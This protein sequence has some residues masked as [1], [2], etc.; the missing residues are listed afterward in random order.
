M[1]SKKGTVYK[2]VLK[3]RK[4]IKKIVLKKKEKRIMF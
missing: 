1:S 4:I 3:K 2:V